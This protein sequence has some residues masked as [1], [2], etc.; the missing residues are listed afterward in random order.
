MDTFLI[1]DC[2]INKDNVD[3]SSLPTAPLPTLPLCL[4]LTRGRALMEE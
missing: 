2:L 1:T 4:G 3:I